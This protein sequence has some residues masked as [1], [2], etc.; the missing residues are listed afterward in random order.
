MSVDKRD[1]F[2]LDIV[3]MFRSINHYFI[4]NEGSDD[5]Y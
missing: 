1:R 2:F 5:K 4:S 3:V